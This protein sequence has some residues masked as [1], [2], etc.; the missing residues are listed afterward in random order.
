MAHAGPGPDL[1]FNCNNAAY[2]SFREQFD[3]IAMAVMDR[4]QGATGS[5]WVMAGLSGIVSRNLGSGP[6]PLV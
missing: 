2:L 3:F 1:L 4:A 5:I 6:M